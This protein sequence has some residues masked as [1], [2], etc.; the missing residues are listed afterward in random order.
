VSQINVVSRSRDVE[1]IVQLNMGSSFGWS[2]ETKC[3]NVEEADEF[4]ETMTRRFPKREYRVV[5]KT[6]TVETEVVSV[7]RDGQAVKP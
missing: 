5:T 4:A 6:T 3:F 2:N 1:V 7:L